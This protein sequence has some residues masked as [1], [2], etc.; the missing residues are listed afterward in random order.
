MR[1]A[2]RKYD[3]SNLDR[4]IYD[5]T[6]PVVVEGGPVSGQEELQLDC[7]RLWV[8]SYPYSSDNCRVKFANGQMAQA[9]FEDINVRE[10]I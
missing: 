3:R 4:W 10:W 7:G 8:W 2:R 5:T 1:R 9:A 6:L